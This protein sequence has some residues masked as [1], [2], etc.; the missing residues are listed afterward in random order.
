[1]HLAVYLKAVLEAVS[2]LKLGSGNENI[3]DND[4]VR[5]GSGKLYIP[6]TAL[7]GVTRHYF[8]K[9]YK[10]KEDFI[11]YFGCKNTSFNP[12]CQSRIIFNDAREL[13]DDHSI[14]VTVRDSVRLNDKKSVV[15]RGKFDYEIIETGAKFGL[16]LEFLLEPSEKSNKLGI[17]EEKREMAKLKQESDLFFLDFISAIDSGD[18]C[19]GG[20]TTRGFGK[21]KVTNPELLVIDVSKNM[22]DYIA[23]SWSNKD[24]WKNAISINKKQNP[25]ERDYISK[26]VTLRISTFLLIRNYATCKIFDSKIVN[27]EHLKNSQKYSIIPGTSWAGSFQHHCRKILKKANLP[28]IDADTL[29]FNM[30]GFPKGKEA[31]KSKITF[32]ESV[33][34]G[35]DTIP[36]TRTAIDRFTGSANDK[37]LFTDAAQY[38][39]ECKLTITI[40]KGTEDYKNLIDLC[41]ADLNDGY[42]SVGGNTA[43]GG[44]IFTITEKGAWES[45][46]TT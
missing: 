40:D 34:Y 45:N 7:A 14:D 41:L 31:Q 12:N 25:L 20:K 10:E 46:V 44:G 13:D 37:S 29:I 2:P 5:D 15:D 32:C 9:P 1:M 6:G 22:N 36:R 17:E 11:K 18:I 42:M 28:N 4:V 23:F 26:T 30:F 39:G 3:S 16:R 35:G 38:G 19:I 43:I 27:S 24:V 8:E 33:I 21:L